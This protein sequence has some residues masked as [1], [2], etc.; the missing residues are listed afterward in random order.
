MVIMNS[1]RMNIVT[2]R[3]KRS[4]H[5]IQSLQTNVRILNKNEFNIPNLKINKYNNANFEKSYD[6][7]MN[8]LNIINITKCIYCKH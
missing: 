1:W 2:F 5:K 7:L 6:N 3:P 4:S 8:S